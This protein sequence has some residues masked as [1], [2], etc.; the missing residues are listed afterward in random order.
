MSESGAGGHD[1]CTI[2]M[3]MDRIPDSNA[4]VLGSK[5]RIGLCAIGFAV[6]SVLLSAC[7]TVDL[8]ETPVSPGACRPDP[9]YFEDVIWPEFIAPA[10]ETK[11]C[12]AD[13][14]C[15][16]LENG[17]SAFR[18]SVNPPIDFTANYNVT[19]RFLNCG[20]PEA[21]PLFTKPVSGVDSH[22]GGDLFDQGGESESAFL[23]WFIT[24]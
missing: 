6:A 23:D 16:Q 9:A 18:V 2:R 4:S 10:D 12:V 22:G 19:T 1:L 20:T 11:S 5:S 15:H 21:S 24:E 13:G 14:G 7:P 17:R 8:G 3:L